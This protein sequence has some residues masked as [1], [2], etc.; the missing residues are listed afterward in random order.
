MSIL[1]LSYLSS[2]VFRRGKKERQPKKIQ[3]KTHPLVIIKMKKRR[4]SCSEQNKHINTNVPQCAITQARRDSCPL[5]ITLAWRLSSILL[6]FFFIL[7]TFQT[8]IVFIFDLVASQ[9]FPMLQR[10]CS[11]T[12]SFLHRE[13]DQ[14]LLGGHMAAPLAR[15]R[16]LSKRF[17]TL[18]DV[19]GYVV[20][21][22]E[23]AI[24]QLKGWIDPWLLIL[25]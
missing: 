11:N 9:F 22:V 15:E 12:D 4:N 17:W 25:E 7:T 2:A 1:V 20:G 8:F 13:L 10:N 21:V 5:L 19:R 24:Y 18:H 3:P 6:L 23:Q 14:V 16:D